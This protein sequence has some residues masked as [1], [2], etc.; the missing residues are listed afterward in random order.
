LRRWTFQLN[1]F[2]KPSILSA[3]FLL[4]LTF[5]T[6]FAQGYIIIDQQSTNAPEGGLGIVPHQPMGQSFK[7]SLSAIN[8]VS[9][10]LYDGD[11]NHV[12]GATVYVNLRSNSISGPILSST[13]PVFL[14]DFFIGIT[15]FFFGNTV[16]LVP[17]AT[18]VLEVAALEG[19]D[20]GAVRSDRSYTRG[21]IISEG[22]SYPGINLWFQE[23]VIVTPEP[24]VLALG[25]LGAG[26]LFWR[27]RT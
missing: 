7:P 16:S 8:Y 22:I 5:S 19:D 6:A 13:A 25:V 27:R 9:L 14:P 3:V 26:L 20:F 2:M 12:A 21:S 24:S 18:Y 23:G 1:D 4:L 10:L 15:N 17:E 11:F